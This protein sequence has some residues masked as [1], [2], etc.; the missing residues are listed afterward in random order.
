MLKWKDVMVQECIYK[1]HAG[2]EFLPQQ[3]LAC[4]CPSG[5]N[6]NYV[7]RG[8][9]SPD[10]IIFWSGWLVRNTQCLC[11]VPSSQN[12][13]T[14]VYGEVDE[15]RLLDMVCGHGLIKIHYY[16][17]IEKSLGVSKCSI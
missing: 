3:I 10:S 15:S 6:T 9:I 14:S 16:K 5:Q 13:M 11:Y 7:A 8:R 2:R 17:G 4:G 1:E 12:T